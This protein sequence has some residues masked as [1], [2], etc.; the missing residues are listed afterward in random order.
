MVTLLAAAQERPKRRRAGA[1]RGRKRRSACAS[2]G[3]SS[4]SSVASPVSISARIAL[5]DPRAISSSSRRMVEGFA[6]AM[7]LRSRARSASRARTAYLQLV[8][9]DGEDRRGHHILGAHERP[10]H[11][12]VDE[13]RRRPGGRAVGQPLLAPGAADP[14]H[15]AAECVELGM[16]DGGHDALGALQL[17]QHRGRDGNVALAVPVVPLVR[18]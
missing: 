9:L 2:A 15:P 6:V 3:G 11:G 16:L 7:A 5:S 13:A 12:L 18:A 14:E 1:V 8:V 10:R 4:R 17:T